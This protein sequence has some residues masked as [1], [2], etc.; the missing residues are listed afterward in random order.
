MTAEIVTPSEALGLLSSMY[1]CKPSLA[2]INN[3]KTALSADESLFLQEIK[4]AIMEIHTASVDELEELLWD[5]TRLFIGPYKLPC[6]PWESVYTSPK[7]LMMQDAADQV[8]KLYR[9]VGLSINTSDIMPDHIGA[10]LNFLALLL[11]SAN[12]E[13]GDREQLAIITDDFISNHILK[14]V[15]EFARDMGNAAETRFY[16][17]LANVTGNIVD[18]MGK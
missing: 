10:E 11:H 6:P 18:F 4:E 14:W 17:T 7:R 12:S 9:E 8:L 3:W 13:T 1:L 15:P 2:A 16:R 5:Y